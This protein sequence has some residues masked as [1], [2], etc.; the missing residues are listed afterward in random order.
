MHGTA[1]GRNDHWYYKGESMST[2]FYG[3]I[4]TTPDVNKLTEAFDPRGGI[5][6]SYEEIEEII[7]AKWPSNRFVTVVS[8]WRKLM[9]RERNIQSRAEGKAIHFLTDDEAQ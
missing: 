7:G 9:F 5:S 1:R 8:R 3:G 4:P 6:I 2:L